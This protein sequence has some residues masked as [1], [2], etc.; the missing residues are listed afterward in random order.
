[1]NPPTGC[2]KQT[3]AAQQDASI[4]TEQCS[5]G[6]QPETQPLATLPGAKQPVGAVGYVSVSS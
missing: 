6:R 5:L 3:S 2:S 1:M 4:P